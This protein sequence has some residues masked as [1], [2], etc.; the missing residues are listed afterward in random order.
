MIK[1]WI[2]LLKL[3]L[4]LLNQNN[5]GPQRVRNWDPL[6]QFTALDKMAFSETLKCTKN[7]FQ[8]SKLHLDK[9]NLWSHLLS[10][11]GKNTRW[12][13]ATKA[14]QFLFYCWITLLLGESGI[15]PRVLQK[16]SL[17][18]LHSECWIEITGEPNLCWIHVGHKL[19]G[20]SS[21]QNGLLTSKICH[22][23]FRLST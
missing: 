20:M 15:S 9:I 16:I 23:L 17:H 13:S 11:Q 10:A 3:S 19:S 7:G 21:R 1:N 4:I 18:E 5:L 12:N 2:R 22:H 14:W 6:D 8:T